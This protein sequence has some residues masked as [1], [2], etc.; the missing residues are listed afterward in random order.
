MENLK[1]NDVY[2]D[3][4]NKEYMFITTAVVYYYYKKYLIRFRI[5]NLFL[6]TR[7]HLALSSLFIFYSSKYLFVNESREKIIKRRLKKNDEVRKFWKN[8]DYEKK[9]KLL[10]LIIEKRK[11]ET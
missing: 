10:D 5:K 8:R 1:K 7:L 4:N 6:P 3:L 2:L 11:N 9:K